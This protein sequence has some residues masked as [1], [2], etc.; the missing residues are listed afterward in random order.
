MRVLMVDDDA[1]IRR[2]LATILEIEGA[3]VVPAAS[4]AEALKTLSGDQFDLVIT[5]M[6]MET[7][8]AGFQVVNAAS[9]CDN[10]P[11]VVVLTAFPV[12]EDEVRAHGDAVIMQKGSDPRG[13]IQQLRSILAL[14]RKP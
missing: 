8:T 12:R 14:A 7:P 6:R 13:L 2:M 9:R 4:A 3:D 11:P 5:D 1:A 10:H